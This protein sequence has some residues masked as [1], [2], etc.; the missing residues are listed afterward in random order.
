MIVSLPL[1]FAV[2]A[3]LLCTAAPQTSDGRKAAEQQQQQ[4]RPADV[5]IAG[6]MLYV[7]P[8]RSYYSL[9]FIVNEYVGNALISQYLCQQYYRTFYVWEDEFEVSRK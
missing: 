6:M 3:A 7:T 8:K 9:H 5:E 1:L 2:F 4:Q